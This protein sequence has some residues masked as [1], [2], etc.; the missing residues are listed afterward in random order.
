LDLAWDN[1]DDL[2]V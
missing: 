2:K 1:P